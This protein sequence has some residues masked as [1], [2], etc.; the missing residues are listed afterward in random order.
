MLRR[1]LIRVPFLLAL[2]LVV[3]V[4]VTSYFAGFSVNTTLA[5][6]DWSVGSV[7]GLNIFYTFPDSNDLLSRPTF[8]FRFQSHATVQDWNLARTT[9]GFHGSA[10]ARVPDSVLIVFPLWL[11]TLLLAGLNWFVW[12]KTRAKYNGR[13]FPVEAA[14]TTNATAPPPN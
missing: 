5:A 12:R 9:W 1:W 4:W 7:H 14:S 10:D 8:R 2:A 13:G 6:R 3:G 11:P